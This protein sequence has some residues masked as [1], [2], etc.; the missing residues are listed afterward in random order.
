M[1][2][3]EPRTSDI[4]SDRFTNWATTTSPIKVKV[5]LSLLITL[6]KKGSAPIHP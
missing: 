6:L 5:D 3:V 2:G 1:T 4:K